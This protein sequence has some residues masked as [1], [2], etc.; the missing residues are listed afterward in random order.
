MV[1]ATVSDRAIS[2]L[3]SSLR[4]R[5]I[6]PADGDY[7]E[8]RRV[9]NGMIDRRPTLIVRPTVAADV[10]AAVNFARDNALLVS[11]RSGGHN[12]AGNAVCDGGMVIDFSAIKAIIVDR[13]ESTVTSV[14]VVCLC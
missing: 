5:I 1:E 9:W 8:A 13:Q 10:V 3:G 6:R 7:D 2:G 11:V 4:G 12:V 14:P